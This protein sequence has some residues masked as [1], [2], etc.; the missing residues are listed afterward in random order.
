M[1]YIHVIDAIISLLKQN[2]S[3]GVIKAYYEGDP[4]LIGKSSLPAICVM[5]NGAKIKVD[6][7]G[8]DG[9]Y[10]TITMKIILDK[11][12]DYGASETVDLTER[13]L[14]TIVEDRDPIT[15]YFVPNSIMG[16][17]RTNYTLGNVTLEQEQQIQY[18]IEARP[19]NM[20]TSEAHISISTRERVYVPN[21]V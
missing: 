5:K 9:I 20:F 11:S 4:G 10:D 19:D 8:T 6:A 14:R 3:A 15:G 17:L 13:K 7:T 16:I 1:A 18:F 12:D 2:L 21:R